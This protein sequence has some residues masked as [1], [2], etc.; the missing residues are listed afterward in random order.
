VADELGHAAGPWV[1][2][3]P[4]L[5]VALAAAAGGAVVTL[6]PWKWPAVQRHLRRG[7]GRLGRWL[8]HQL[9]RAP[10]SSILA[11][12]LVGTAAARSQTETP[13]A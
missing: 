13:P 6:R 1:H 10:L 5:S 8:V 2:R 9:A 3:H 7:P 4:V 11:A 12:L